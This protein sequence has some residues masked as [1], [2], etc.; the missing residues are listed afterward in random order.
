MYF[1]PAR[2]A[3][4]ASSIFA[5]TFWEQLVLNLVGP[6]VTIILGTAIVG[7]AVSLVARRAQ[8]RREDHELRARLCREVTEA[9]TALYL[10]TQHYSR[11]GK[12]NLDPDQQTAFRDA[13]DKDYLESRRAGTALE[14]LLGLYFSDSKPRT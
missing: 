12:D 9:P 6:L 3:M 13:L 14:H 5:F 11:A 8:E 1:H 2:L 4:V 10:A 7:F